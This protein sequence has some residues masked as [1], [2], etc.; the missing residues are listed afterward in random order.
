MSVS[1]SIWELYTWGSGCQGP[2]TMT[3]VV[4]PSSYEKWKRGCV[5]S[6][7]L[8][9]KVRK[10]KWVEEATLAMKS[11]RT[12][13]T[14][15]TYDR[16]LYIMYNISKWICFPI[17]CLFTLWRRVSTHMCRT[18]HLTVV[19]FSTLHEASQHLDCEQ[20]TWGCEQDISVEPCWD[21]HQDSC[22]ICVLLKSINFF[23]QGSGQFPIRL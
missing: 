16:Y 7:A 23:V 6:L 15:K 14:D 19:L 20:G 13:I 4:R 12:R 10:L 5:T 17:T 8:D 1:S 2:I 11:S 21:F 18:R 22:E 3:T 9:A